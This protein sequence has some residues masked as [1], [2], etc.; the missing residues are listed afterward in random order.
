MV[1]T[2]IGVSPENQARLFE[3]F[4]QIGC[5]KSSPLEGTALGLHLSRKLTELLGRGSSFGVVLAGD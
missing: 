5:L 3:A 4:E 2:G 1:D